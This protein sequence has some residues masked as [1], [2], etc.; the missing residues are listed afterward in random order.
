MWN[1]R[2][3]MSVYLWK[4]GELF[5]N[6]DAEELMNMYRFLHLDRDSSNKDI[7]E[8]SDSA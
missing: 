2:C 8:K 5:Q 1:N 7:A 6:I 4:D 3:Y